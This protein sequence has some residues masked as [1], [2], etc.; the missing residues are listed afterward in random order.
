MR[1]SRR[2]QRNLDDVLIVDVDAHHYENEHFDEIL[3]FME[4]DVFRQLA[5]SSRSKTARSISCRRPS[6]IRTWA[7]G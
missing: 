5:M 1:A 6:A 3:P 7:A 4:N 2:W